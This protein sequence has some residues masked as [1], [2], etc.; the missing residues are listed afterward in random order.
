M[1]GSLGGPP[2]RGN[3]LVTIYGALLHIIL[4]AGPLDPES[5]GY[6]DCLKACIPFMPSVVYIVLP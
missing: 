4:F 3:L 1:E 6:W 5:W 2:V